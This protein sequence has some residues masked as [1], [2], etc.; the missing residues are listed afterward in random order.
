MNF[1]QPS[2]LLLGSFLK[3]E[4]FTKFCKANFKERSNITCSTLN[5]LM[6]V[7]LVTYLFKDVIGKRI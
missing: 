5:P 3:E 6:D 7:I 2:I 1:S 4:E